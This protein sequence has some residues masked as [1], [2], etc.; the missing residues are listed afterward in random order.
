MAQEMLSYKKRLENVKTTLAGLSGNGY[1]NVVHYL[2][3]IPKQGH[4][5][6]SETNL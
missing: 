1:S 3:S 2:D 4:G 6:F 5:I